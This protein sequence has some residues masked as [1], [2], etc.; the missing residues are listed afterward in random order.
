[1]SADLVPADLGP[2]TVPIG[3]AERV[4]ARCPD[5]NEPALLW[6]TAT[7]CAALAQ[8]W[9]GH[10]QEKNEIKSAQMFVEIELGQRLGPNPGQSE[11]ERDADGRVL[12]NSRDDWDIPAYVVSDIRRYHGHRDALVAM[13][14]EGSRSRRSLLLALDRANAVDVDPAE[15]DITVGDFRDVLDLEPGSVALV[16]TDPPYPREY[17]PL[18]SD[19]GKHSAEWLEPGGS[20]VACCGHS[21]FGEAWNRLAEH[22]RYWWVLCLL[23][24][25]G[26]D[27]IP[28]KNVSAGWKPLLWFVKDNRRTGFMLADTL[29]GSPPRKT[30]PTGDTG[31]WAQGVAEFEPIISALTAPDDLVV[32][33]FAGSG[34]MGL[35]ALRFGRRFIGADLS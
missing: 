30:I 27:M 2:G 33:P 20:L 24:S 5:V 10:G 14:R 11:R 8:K 32:D 22:L 35:A 12:P 13:V 19:L 3:F 4:L 25:H 1:V 29:R 23:H 31:D 28:G 7:T 34:S 21:I 16:L 17:L 9:N 18:W 15:L 6:D 26:T